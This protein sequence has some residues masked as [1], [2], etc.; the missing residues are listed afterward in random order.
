MILILENYCIGK[1]TLH[2]PF[3]G[4]LLFFGTSQRSLSSQRGYPEWYILLMV[5]GPDE[6][7]RVHLG[8]G[9]GGNGKKK[10]HGKQ[11]STLCHRKEHVD[12]TVGNGKM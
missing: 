6:E 11:H 2:D 3:R 12:D 1:S 9:S 4:H 8:V 5:W 10:T 7:P